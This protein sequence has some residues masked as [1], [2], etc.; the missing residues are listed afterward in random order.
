MHCRTKTK[1]YK[2]CQNEKLV[3]ITVPE[4][5]T[6]VLLRLPSLTCTLYVKVHILERI[7]IINSKFS[8]ITLHIVENYVI[9]SMTEAIK[10][11]PSS[12]VILLHF[13]Y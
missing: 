2:F 3:K 13:M 5:I 8:K 7:H 12:S 10:C 1:Q 6:F 9:F 11:R 4:L